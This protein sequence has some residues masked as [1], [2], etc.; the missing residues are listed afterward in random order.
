VSK[1]TNV[2]KLCGSIK[3]VLSVAGAPPTALAGGPSAVNQ[4]VKAIAIARA[5]LIGEGS[6]M[7]VQP[8]FDGGSVRCALE[9]YVAPP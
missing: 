6:D 7:L 4:A 8:T 3:Y 1:E 2:K 9:M 5:D